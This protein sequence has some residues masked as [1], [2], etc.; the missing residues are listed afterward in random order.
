MTYWDLFSIFC[1]QI[2]AFLGEL[3]ISVDS[4]FP[5]LSE[6]MSQLMKPF[7]WMEKEKDGH[8]LEFKIPADTKSVFY[9]NVLF[10]LW[11]SKL[12]TL[13]KSHLLTSY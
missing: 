12:V 8:G 2:L 11:R 3:K 9:M 6:G 5:G 4:I 10:L 13:I 7:H 1:K